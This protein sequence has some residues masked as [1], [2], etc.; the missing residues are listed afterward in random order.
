MCARVTR[1]VSAATVDAPPARTRGESTAA[2]VRRGVTSP[3]LS[4]HTTAGSLASDCEAASTD[5][6]GS[7]WRRG[8]EG[9]RA[10]SARTHI[11]VRSSTHRR[12]VS[13][14]P[15]NHRPRARLTQTASAYVP[16]PEGPLTRRERGVVVLGWIPVKV[17]RGPHQYR[18]NDAGYGS[19]PEREGPRRPRRSRRSLDRRGRPRPTAHW[20]LSPLLKTS[21]GRVGEEGRVV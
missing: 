12:D 18:I 19:H 4:L 17:V 3:E 8:G 7:D 11:S 1:C 20:P 10:L 9:P 21:K 6:A 5:N 15:R 16:C 13:P 2:A 14:R